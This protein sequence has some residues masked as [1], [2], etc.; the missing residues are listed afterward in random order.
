MLRKTQLATL[1]V[2][3]NTTAKSTKLARASSPPMVATLVSVAKTDVWLVPRKPVS[4]SVVVSEV[5]PVPKTNTVSTHLRP[6]VVMLMRLAFAKS[7]RRIAPQC[8]S[9]SVVVMARPT[10]TP[11]WPLVMGRE[12]TKKANA[13]AL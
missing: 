2:S 11:A 1:P 8:T 3:A 13:K 9:R 6:S 4:R 5:Q 12:S 7:V 10:P